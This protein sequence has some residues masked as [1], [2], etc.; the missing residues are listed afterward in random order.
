ML[1][2]N[3]NFLIFGL[4]I[5]I[6]GITVTRLSQ[7]CREN[8][9]NYVMIVSDGTPEVSA[10][11]V[12]PPLPIECEVANNYI[13][14]VIDLAENNGATVRKRCGM[15]VH[16]GLK[17]II[18]ISKE[19]FTE[20]SI[21]HFRDNLI[22]NLSSF[23]NSNTPFLFNGVE[24]ADLLPFELVKDVIRTY[25][26]NQNEIN[27]FLA[28][29]RRN[30]EMARSIAT[31]VETQRFNNCSTYSDLNGYSVL[32]GKFSSVSV[33][34]FATKETI[35]FRQHQTTLSLKKIINWCSLLHGLFVASDKHRMSYNGSSTEEQT[36]ET[37]IVLNVRRYSTVQRLWEMMRTEEGATEEEMI[38]ELG[39]S[40]ISVRRHVS[41]LRK[42]F[43]SK[44]V[45][46]THTKLSMGNMKKRYQVVRE[47]KVIIESIEP[48]LLPSNIIGSYYLW[49]EIPTHI[50]S[51]FELRKREFEN[52]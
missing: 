39:I 25:G 36:H 15:H 49:L 43:N 32:N 46:I 47:Y 13:R 8:S 19:E 50:V 51:F 17:P 31:I 24:Q 28:P 27:T 4:E 22:S 1:L 41:E 6:S 23:R 48:T 52:R 5:E 44:S 42:R 10:E 45:I 11:I 12:F 18:N 20:K 40:S 33:N 9:L 7:L 34:S 3:N 30:F 38:N 14:Q 29:S 26:K 2:N 16:F 21:Q 37:P 35:E